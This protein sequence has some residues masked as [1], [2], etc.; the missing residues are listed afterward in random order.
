[1]NRNIIRIVRETSSK[2]ETSFDE[3]FLILFNYGIVDEFCNLTDEFLAINRIEIKKE[4]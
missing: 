4:A 1:M 2:C 3:L